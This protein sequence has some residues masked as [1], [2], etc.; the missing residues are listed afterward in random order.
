M[1]RTSR[2]QCTAARIARDHGLGP[3]QDLA[4]EKEKLKLTLSTPVPPLRHLQPT[5]PPE[6][7][8]IWLGRTPPP[9]N[10]KGGGRRGK[11]K[12]G[13]GSQN[14]DS[15]LPVSTQLPAVFFANIFFSING[16]ADILEISSYTY[17]LTH[18][19]ARNPLPFVCSAITRS[20]SYVPRSFRWCIACAIR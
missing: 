19:L 7:T 12:A 2:L 3:R 18:G 13:R 9:L 15:G 17:L 20:F 1:K 8:R 5:R 16:F 6:T 10:G 4:T 11:D 14:R